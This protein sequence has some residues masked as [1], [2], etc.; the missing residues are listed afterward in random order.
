MTP[1]AAILAMMG[2][3]RP[4]LPIQPGEVLVK[5]CGVRRCSDASL[6]VAAGANLIGV[7]FATSKR[8]ASRE[9]AEALVAEVR[10]F[11]E[12]QMRVPRGHGHVFRAL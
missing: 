7:I 2:A 3:E 6:A 1:G 8:Q 9:Q 5:V 10:R 11:G 12:R 4:L